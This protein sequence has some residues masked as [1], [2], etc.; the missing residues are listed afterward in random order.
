MPPSLNFTSLKSRAI[1]FIMRA[2]QY[3]VHRGNSVYVLNQ[4]PPKADSSGINKQES[5]SLMVLFTE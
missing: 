1:E 2:G 3:S 4:E 5:S